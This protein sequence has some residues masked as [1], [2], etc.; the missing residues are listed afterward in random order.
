[1]PVGVQNLMISAFGY[2]WKRRRFGGIFDLELRRFKERESFTPSQWQDYQVIELRKLL[3]HSFETVPFYNSLFKAHGFTS[4]NLK[5]TELDDLSKFPVLTKE[6]LRK[7]G[8]SSLLSSKK[9]KRG[10]FFSSS[11]S[12]GTPTRILFSELMHQRWSAAFE[13]RIRNWAGVTHLDGRGMIGGR[14]IVPDGESKGPFY[15]VNYSEKQV[16]FSAYHISPETGPDY[17][18]ALGKYR[19]VYMTGYAMSNYLL[20]NVF[21]NAEIDVPGLKA[22]ITS[23]EKLTSEMRDILEKV[24]KCKTYDSYSGVEACGLISE[25]EYG[26]LLISPDVGIMEILNDEG[27]SCL[28]GEEGEI[29]STGF[30]N[31]DQP[32]IRYKIG[33]RVR[34][35]RNQETLC[36]RNMIKI[37][38]ITGRTEDLIKGPDGRQM[39]RFH[40]LY[41]N[42]GGLI[43]GQIVQHKLDYFTIR[44][45]VDKTTYKK[46][47]SE[48]SIERRLISQLGSVNVSFEYPDQ[49]ATGPNGKYKA[50]IS[51]L[52]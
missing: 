52:S 44:L 26:Q 1:M 15:R 22:V 32:L 23:S 5:K 35:A 45:L 46:D 47:E 40:G 36:G 9:E 49:I 34:L 8:I 39:V 33:D 38:E 7:N 48:K 28:P 42:I 25:N 20:A 17:A 3:I 37:D 21:H 43:S 19:P 29:Y 51:E 18:R 16:Y 11:G 2:Y 50:V 6:D 27:K 24:Y 4:E 31:Y 14:R 10:S 13:A 12:T 41:L 30:L